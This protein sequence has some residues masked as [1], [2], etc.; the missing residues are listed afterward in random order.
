MNSSSTGTCLTRVNQTASPFCPPSATK[1]SSPAP[2]GTMSQR[3]HISKCYCYENKSCMT[4]AA[5]SPSVSGFKWIYEFSRC[6]D[7]HTSCGLLL[8]KSRSIFFILYTVWTIVSFILTA[9]RGGG[10]GDC[11]IMLFT[12]MSVFLEYWFICDKLY[13]WLAFTFY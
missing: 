5:F 2:R 8:L 3:L 9:S 1:P 12:L 10:K 6:E 11:V 4:A 13:Y 7:A